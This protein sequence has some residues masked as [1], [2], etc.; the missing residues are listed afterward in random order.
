M[1]TWKPA[2]DLLNK[3]G[4]LSLEHPMCGKF[5]EVLDE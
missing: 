5:L 2:L 3:K 4:K 1:Q